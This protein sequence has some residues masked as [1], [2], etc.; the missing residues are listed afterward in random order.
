MFHIQIDYAIL[1]FIGY[2][3]F[4]SKRTLHNASTAYIYIQNENLSYYFYN[5]NICKLWCTNVYH[6]ALE[7]ASKQVK[8]PMFN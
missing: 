2:S 7:Y 3:N 6:D 5:Q 8:N 1:I 4:V